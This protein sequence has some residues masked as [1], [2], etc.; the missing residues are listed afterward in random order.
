[1][2]TPIVPRDATGFTS[3]PVVKARLHPRTGAASRTRTTSWEAMNS[4]GLKGWHSHSVAVATA[5]RRRWGRMHPLPRPALL[6]SGIWLSS[7]HLATISPSGKGTSAFCLFHIES[8]AP[9][10]PDHLHALKCSD[11][12]EETSYYVLRKT[13]WWKNKPF[14]G[15]S[16]V[17]NKNDIRVQVHRA[18]ENGL[19]VMCY[20]GK[21]RLNKCGKRILLNLNMTFIVSFPKYVLVN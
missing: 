11:D 7:H 1:M 4:A 15:C 12:C 10:D 2:S 13:K 9:A 17:Q 19:N 6:W 8:F 3:G 16:S 14:I 5:A 21:G 18:E 20:G